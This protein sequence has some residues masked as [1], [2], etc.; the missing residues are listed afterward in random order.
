MQITI[1]HDNARP[2]ASINETVVVQTSHGFFN[3][4]QSLQYQHAL[5]DI[6]ELITAVELSFAELSAE[7]LDDVFLSL[8]KVMEGAMIVRGSSSN[9][10]QHMQ[11]THLRAQGSLPAVIR[12]VKRLFTLVTRSMHNSKNQ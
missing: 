12:A 3:S 9:K 5:K 10:L 2:H 8:Q 1:Q 6:N 11:K 4:I 7:K